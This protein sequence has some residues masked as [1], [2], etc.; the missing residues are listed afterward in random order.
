MSDINHRGRTI[1]HRVRTELKT[2][3]VP[4]CPPCLFAPGNWKSSPYSSTTSSVISLKSFVLVPCVAS[5]QTTLPSANFFEHFSLDRGLQDNEKVFFFQS[6]FV[7]ISTLRF[8]VEDNV[9]IPHFPHLLHPCGN[10]GGIIVVPLTSLQ[11]ECTFNVVD[12][13]SLD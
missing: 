7:I 6:C 3:S 10:T 4:L 11:L 5:T 1:P 8:I 9:V 12:V 13:L 2:Q